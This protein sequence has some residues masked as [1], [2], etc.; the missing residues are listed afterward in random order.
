LHLE[1]LLAGVTRRVRVVPTAEYESP[2]LDTIIRNL[3]I[4]MPPRM[5]KSLTVSVFFPAWAWIDNPWLR[6]LYCSYSQTLAT[7]H[8]MLTRQV[9]ES[10]WYQERWGDRFRMADDDNLKTR[11]SN[12]KRGAR[13]STSVGGTVTGQGGDIIVCDDPHNVKHAESD[14]IREA[15]LVWWDKTM[16]TRLNDPKTGARIIVMQRVHEH[17]LSGHVLQQGGYDHLSLPMELEPTSARPTRIGWEDPRTENGELLA[18]D[19]FGEAE[20]IAAK[21]TLGSYGYAGQMQQRPAPAE[22]GMFKRLWWKPYK[23][24]TLPKLKTVE[25]YLD[26]AFK[27]GVHN[28]FS[29][30]ALWG[31]DGKGGGYVLN[32]WRRRVAFPALIRLGHEA[33]AWSEEHFP[34]M[35]ILLV[36]EDKASGQSAIQTFSQPYHTVDG[37]LPKLPVHSYKLP[38]GQS[39]IARAE[40]VT[41]LVEGGSVFVPERAAWLEDWLLEHDKFPNDDHDD[42]VDT[43]SM[44]LT[45]NLLKDR[46]V[47]VAPTSIPQRSK[48][49]QA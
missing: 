7:E 25:L 44:A 43:T 34:G 37:E 48:W 3:L 40:G 22:G 35:A 18:P 21:R 26:S 38:A 2:D 31:F 32:V 20:V 15:T 11:F 28:D 30:F 23:P 42:Q 39:K 27:E 29:V 12:D 17:D 6:F 36:I 5:M 14:A 41:A 13:L 4:N 8:S 46:P 24:E 9:I 33:Y 47:I 1:A 49:R 10:D 19:R 16:S 45:R